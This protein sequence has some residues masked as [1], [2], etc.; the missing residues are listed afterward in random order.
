[1]MPTTTVRSPDD[2][3]DRI[4]RAAERAGMTSHAFILHAIAETIFHRE[5]FLRATKE[6]PLQID[7]R[8]YASDVDDQ[9]HD[10]RGQQEQRAALYDPDPDP[11]RDKPRPSWRGGCQKYGPARS[12]AAV[13]RAQGSNGI[14]Y[15]SLRDP[16]GECIAI[17]K[18]RLLTPV[19]QGAHYCYVWA[20][21]SIVDG[22]VKTEYHRE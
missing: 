13:L 20:G 21:E 18:P 7:L 3:K 16:G 2:L 22:Y 5:R 17:F 6:S 11:V 14:V 1:M 9:F 15:E 19:V 12:I 8:S 4:A 10:I